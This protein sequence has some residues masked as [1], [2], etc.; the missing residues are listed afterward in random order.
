[1]DVYGLLVYGIV[2]FPHLEDYIDL[3]VVDA[4]LAK[5]DGGENLVIAVLANT[6][7]TLNYYYE[8]NEKSLRG[9]HAPYRIT[10]RTG[11]KPYQ[12]Q[13]G[14]NNG[15]YFKKIRHAW[16]SIIKRGH[17]WG[18]R[19]FGAS[20][21][22]KAW[23]KSQI[24][25][26]NLP[27]NDPQLDTGK[28][29]A[30]EN[31]EAF[32][33]EEPEATLGQI[34]WKQRVL[35]RKLKAALEA[36]VIAQEEAGL[37][38]VGE[39]IKLGIRRGKFTQSSNNVGFAKKPNQEKRKGEANDVLVESVLLRGRG[40]P[41]PPY[42]TQIHLKGSRPAATY[43]NPPPLVAPYLP[44][45]LPP[46][47]PPYQLKSDSED[48]ASSNNMRLAQQN[49]RRSIPRTLDPI[50]MSYTELLPLLLQQ[51]LLDMIP[52]KPIQ[53]PYPKSYDPNTKCDFHDGVIGHSTEKCWGLKHKVQDVI[54]GGW[55]NFK[56]HRP[57]VKSNPLPTHGGVSI[58]AISHESWEEELKEAQQRGTNRRGEEEKEAGSPSDSAHQVEDGSHSSQQDQGKSSLVVVVGGNGNPCPKPLIIHY[59]P[60]SK[61]R[62]TLIIEVLAKLAYKDNHAIPWRY[63]EGK[64]VP[65]IQ[66][67]AE[68]PKAVTNI[69]GVGGVTRSGRIYCPE[70]LRKKDSTLEKKGKE[71][72]GPKRLV[73]EGKAIEFLKLIRHK[74]YRNLL[75]KVLNEAHVA[76]IITMEK[77]E[78]IINNI[79]TSRHLSFF[80]VEVS[81]EGRG[82]NQPLRIDVKC[83]N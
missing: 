27:F 15:E 19:S 43:M 40:K 25:R 83:G 74:G 22:Y 9:R 55:L 24:E 26:T 1:M 72:E 58:N 7:Y 70:G 8:K 46:Y 28:M 29:P 73:T 16:K 18:T 59:N 20:S 11:L 56:E 23:A 48:V 21:S 31:R 62:V 6:Y 75:L 39:R 53:L 38:V 5:R 71:L 2:L 65:L 78:G 61:P 45:C 32:K 68:L 17:E 51:N 49:L 30:S 13:N 80:E 47:V 57:N 77:F 10:T 69:A 14:L 41:P 36:Q 33:I 63:R 82:H 3:T 34:E 44:K 37:V 52:L 35:K 67:K 4:F 12:S 76:Q 50:P 81:T 60:A 64:V 42:P 79:T 66:E 54:D